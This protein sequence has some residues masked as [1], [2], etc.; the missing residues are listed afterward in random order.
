VL[1]KTTVIFFATLFFLYQ[2]VQADSVHPSLII[3]TSNQFTFNAEDSS[4][5]S[6]IK[7]LNL[8]AVKAVTQHLNHDLPL[9]E[10]AA[11]KLVKERIDAIGPNTFNKQILQAYQPLIRAMQLGVDRIP[12]V[13][14]DNQFVIYGT[15]DIPLALKK[16]RQWSV[17]R[18]FSDE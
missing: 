3:F 15:T 18:A 4:H 13:V 5:F 8:D 16:Y 9:N 6:D 17:E 1:T 14:F 2:S 12:A 10:D 11:L 7:I